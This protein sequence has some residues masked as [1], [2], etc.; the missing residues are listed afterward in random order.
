MAFHPQSAGDRTRTDRIGSLAGLRA[1]RPRVTRTLTSRITLLRWRA[2]ASPEPSGRPPR[3]RQRERWHPC[4]TARLR[5]RPSGHGTRTCPSADAAWARRAGGGADTRRHPPRMQAASISRS[6]LRRGTSRSAS[7]QRI[8]TR[9][10]LWHPAGPPSYP[11]T[12]PLKTGAAAALRPATSSCPLA[13]FAATA[14]GSTFCVPSP[15][16]TV[17]S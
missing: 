6:T 14:Y 1:D 5:S 3:I 9:Y 12:P 17:Q 7:R 8:D 11:P 16:A 13:S 4:S 15:I 2:A 10:C